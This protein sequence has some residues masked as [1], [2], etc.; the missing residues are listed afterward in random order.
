MTATDSTQHTPVGELK[1]CTKCREGKPRTEYHVGKE[2]PDGRKATCKTCMQEQRR[3]KYRSQRDQETAKRRARKASPEWQKAAQERKP[4]ILARR[5][6]RIAAAGASEKTCT[7]CALTLAATPDNFHRSSTGALGLSSRCKDCTAEWFKGNVYTVDRDRGRETART[8][9][10]RNAEAILLKAKERRRTD[11][12]YSLRTRVS[13]GVRQSIGRTRLGTSWMNLLPYSA[14]DL[15]DHLESLFAEGM[16]WDRLLAGEI[17][18]DHVIPVS[19][20]NPTTPDCIEFRMCWSLRN[21]QPL[22]RE[23]NRVKSD[24]LPP[25]FTELWNALHQEATRG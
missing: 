15:K 21:L 10:R 12:A 7:T 3:A 11:A 16:T 18:I 24:R 8:T 25:N 4:A 20:F 1:F 5:A 23:D 22:W 9:Y 6:E 2:Y 17:E 14:L 19:F 13:S